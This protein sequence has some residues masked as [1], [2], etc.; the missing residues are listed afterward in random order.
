MVETSILHDATC[1]R[2]RVGSAGRP[3]RG[4]E[5]RMA[6][7]GRGMNADLAGALDFLEARPRS[8]K[9]GRNARTTGVDYAGAKL[10]SALL[11]S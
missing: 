3:T 5:E 1:K 7:A 9:K 6:L 11:S 10:I 4:P 8:K 2:R